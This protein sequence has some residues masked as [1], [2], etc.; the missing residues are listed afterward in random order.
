LLI[1]LT[2]PLNVHVKSSDA[3]TI[4]DVA[5]RFGLATHVL[6]HWESMGLLRPGRDGSGQR[7]YGEQDVRQVAMI[8]LGKDAGFGL[9]DLHALL[10]AENPM[11]RTDILKRRVAD[12]TDEINRAT[13]ARDFIEKALDCPLRWDECPDAR[14][15]IQRYI[16]PA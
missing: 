16:P 13:A 7:R 6:R 10:T 8:R 12:L 2:V 4:G 5:N 1:G 9:G 15:H 3:M 14:E 11:D